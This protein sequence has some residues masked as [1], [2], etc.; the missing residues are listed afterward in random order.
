[1]SD[2]PTRLLFVCTGNICRSPMA[3]FYARE[4]AERRNLYVEVDSGGTMGLVDYAPPPNALSV[5]RDVGIIMDDHRSKAITPEMMDWAD[6]VFVMTYEHAE[7]LRDR[8]PDRSDHVEL[9]GP[10]GRKA[11]EIADPMGRWRPA[12]K[13]ARDQ[14]VECIDSVIRG[15]ERPD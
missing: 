1:M 2:T 11:P 3:L 4:A 9:L 5:M 7:T 14:I 10:Y 6:R 15:L 8:F 13:R 12:Y